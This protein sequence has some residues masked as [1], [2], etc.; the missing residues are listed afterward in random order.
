MIA[1]GGGYYTVAFVPGLEPVF[2]IP[3]ASS[4]FEGTCW[5]VIFM[6]NPHL[7]STPLVQ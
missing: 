6:F 7:A 1:A 5:K 3:D 2:G 4:K